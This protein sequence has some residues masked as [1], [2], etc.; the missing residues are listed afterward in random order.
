MESE[1][2]PKRNLIERYSLEWA[3]KSRGISV[4]E[5]KK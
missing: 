2:K 1:F 4:D 3:A 5:L